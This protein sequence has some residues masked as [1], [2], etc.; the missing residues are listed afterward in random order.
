MIKIWVLLAATSLQVSASRLD[1]HNNRHEVERYGEARHPGPYLASWNCASASRFPIIEGWRSEVVCLQETR[2][3]KGELR[4]FEL[5]NPGYRVYHSMVAEHS[6]A[7]KAGKGVCVMVSREVASRQL[8]PKGGRTKELHDSGR[9]VHAVCDL[10]EDKPVHVISYYGPVRG[11]RDYAKR[12]D[13][14]EGLGE[15]VA[16]LSTDNV[17]VA[18]DFNVQLD[19]T[20]F[21]EVGLKQAGMVD[22]LAREAKP[23]PTFYGSSGSETRIDTVFVK[24][25]MVSEVGHIRV[26]KPESGYGHSPIQVELLAEGAPPK[27]YEHVWREVPIAIEASD[28]LIEEADRRFFGPLLRR[29]EGWRNEYAVGHMH[30]DWS[31]TAMKALNWMQKQLGGRSTAKAKGKVV[32]TGKAK[33]GGVSAADRL[34]VDAARINAAQRRALRQHDAVRAVGHSLRAEKR[35]AHDWLR[36]RVDALRLWDK[37]VAR[38]LKQ[39]D[40]DAWPILMAGPTEGGVQQLCELWMARVRKIAEDERRERVWAWRHRM[41]QSAKED[42]AAVYRWLKRRDYLEPCYAEV[43]VNGRKISIIGT[44]AMHKALRE[45]WL[46]I[47][48]RYDSRERPNFAAIEEK[49]GEHIKRVECE[50]E[51]FRAEEVA[52]VWRG[53]KRKASPGPDGWAPGDF[54]L[55][56]A[57]AAG[58]Y[59]KILNKLRDGDEWPQDQA[60]VYQS[61]LPKKGT[62]L[63][64]R[65]PI[66]VASCLY[67][68][69]S[70]IVWKR[71]RGWMAQW[72]HPA[73]KGAIR[74]RSV[75]DAQQAIAMEL[76]KREGAE[77]ALWVLLDYKKCFDYLEPRMLHSLLVRMG[78]PEGVLRPWLN[79]HEK[80][81]RRLK[82]LGTVGV[83]FHQT[84][85]VLQGCS[86]SLVA[87]SALT[88]LW[89][90][91]VQGVVAGT[92]LSVFID[93]RAFITECE[94]E[95]DFIMA[96]VCS[97]S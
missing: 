62:K 56:G 65:R 84:N 89:S 34:V 90:R 8:V 32:T 44:D 9:M 69:Y 14:W 73:L 50:D 53:L 93:D 66:G 22:A 88:S 5:R 48:R 70:A 19:G 17:I 49:Y 15:L 58:V 6:Q 60:V 74:G 11:A 4:A 39:R 16:G 51:Q 61:M 24:E 64:D 83:S 85:A 82:L 3:G 72:A 86:I 37:V 92:V 54:R 13:Y 28:E 26:H 46:G 23:G 63:T 10:G 21:M 67:R 57:R 76:E 2:L 35:H 75:Q 78:A 18:G 77:G 59:T 87:V 25:R 31:R 20:T 38:A 94:E 12:Q 47:F 81:E 41:R 30:E 97:R 40:M 27:H 52:E 29:S 96:A 80:M 43:D 79:F 95:E 91:V 36:H 1:Q 55:L 71:L 45:E 7:E 68:H 33:S 42:S